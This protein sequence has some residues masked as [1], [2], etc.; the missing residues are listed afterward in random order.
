MPLKFSVRVDRVMMPAPLRF[1]VA[2]PA[3]VVAPDPTMMPVSDHAAALLTVS[4]PIPPRVPLLSV[5]F[6]VDPMRSMFSMP[7]LIR[8]VPVTL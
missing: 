6:A 8:V 2:K 5:R 1:S 4:V 3:M 7:P